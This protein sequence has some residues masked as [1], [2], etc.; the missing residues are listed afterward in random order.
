MNAPALMTDWQRL[1]ATRKSR[2]WHETMADY[3]LANPTATYAEIGAY[4]KRGEHTVALIVNTDSFKAYFRKRRQQHSEMIDAEVRGKLYKV[5]NTSLDAMLTSLE[6]KRD[7]IPLELLHRTVDTTLKSLG[8]G[9]PSPAGTTVNV[10]P[11]T[12]SVAV[13]VEDLEAARSALRASQKT[14]DHVPSIMDEPEPEPPPLG[15]SGA[16][17]S[18]DSPST[19]PTRIEDLA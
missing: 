4:L 1:K 11:T 13:S 17:P 16:D 7:S 12:V 15:G 3:M 10:G 18:P 19:S 5:A 14:I 6:K 2:W 8:Y 9:A